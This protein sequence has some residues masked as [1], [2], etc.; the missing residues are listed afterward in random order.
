MN[1]QVIR[2]HFQPVN[3]GKTFSTIGLAVDLYCSAINPAKGGRWLKS[4]PRLAAL[5]ELV[6]ERLDAHGH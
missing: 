3:A 5:T 1:N 4:A 6:G 2:G